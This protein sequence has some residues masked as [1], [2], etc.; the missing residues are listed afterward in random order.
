MQDNLGLQEPPFDKI[1]AHLLYHLRKR[2]IR[3]AGEY[4]QR[5]G[6]GLCRSP[7]C[8]LSFAIRIFSRDITKP[9]VVQ[10]II[11]VVPRESAYLNAFKRRYVYL[12]TFRLTS[13]GQNP[14]AACVRS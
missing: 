4:F 7:R 3:E 8:V 13:S 2:P 5:L 9:R 6:V 14:F 10:H 11:E 1:F 12:M